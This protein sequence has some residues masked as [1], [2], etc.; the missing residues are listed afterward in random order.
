MLEVM[1]VFA[2]KPIF[3]YKMM[4]YSTIA[5]GLLSF[6]VWAHH[7]F[8]SGMDP[9]L[10]TPFSITT[11]MISVP[12]AIMVFAMIATLVARLDSLHRGDAVRAGRIG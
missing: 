6:V 8:V 7:M 3:G 12:F 10:A 11:I 4:V 2:R 1:P 9:R 5:A